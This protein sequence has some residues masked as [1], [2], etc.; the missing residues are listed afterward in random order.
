MI[1]TETATEGDPVHPYTSTWA[2]Y[3]WELQKA[4][5]ARLAAGLARARCDGYVLTIMP[6]RPWQP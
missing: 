4:L 5:C 6:W 2:A 1:L 3:P